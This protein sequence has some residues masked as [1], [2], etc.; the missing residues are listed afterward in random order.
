LT[1]IRDQSDSEQCDEPIAVA[2]VYARLLKNNL[3]SLKIQKPFLEVSNI[4]NETSINHVA[5]NN[6]S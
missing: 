3:L 6:A 1:Y 2:P 5:Q 4:E